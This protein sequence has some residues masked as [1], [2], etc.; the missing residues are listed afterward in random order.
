MLLGFQAD[1][2]GISD[3]IKHLQVLNI[4]KRVIY[5]GRGSIVWQETVILRAFFIKVDTTY[6]IAHPA[7]RV[8]AG[9]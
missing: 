1:L 7:A 3:E 2:G 6:L 5:G 8:Y 4:L 9:A